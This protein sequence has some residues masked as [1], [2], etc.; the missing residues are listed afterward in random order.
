MLACAAKQWTPQDA[1]ATLVVAAL[2]GA[3]PKRA[4]G[5][6]CRG[7]ELQCKL[8]VTAATAVWTGRAVQ[9]ENDDLEKLVLRF[10]IRP[11]DGAFERMR[12][13]ARGYPMP[14]LHQRTTARW[15]SRRHQGAQGCRDALAP[16]IR[17]VALDPDI[18]ASKGQSIERSMANAAGGGK[19]IARISSI[20]ASAAHDPPRA[21]HRLASRRDPGIALGASGF[22]CRHL[23]SAA[24]RRCPGRKET[25]PACPSRSPNSS[26]PET[27]AET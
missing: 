9:A 3:A 21:L 22:G 26:A 17:A 1:A 15:W 20:P 16:R 25:R 18:L 14:R 10:C 2:A 7:A 13:N 5:T 27:L 8:S 24:A 23:E 19:A 6:A 11:I 12:S 4:Y